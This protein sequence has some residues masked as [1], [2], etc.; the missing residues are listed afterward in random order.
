MS[1]SIL[2][3][4][5]GGYSR[6][7]Q[8]SGSKWQD[9]S[10]LEIDNTPLLVN[11]LQKSKQYYDKFCISVNSFKRKKKYDKIIRKHV[12]DIKPHF[13]VDQKRT[14]FKGVFLGISS[15]IVQHP[16]KK[17]QLLSSDRPF[18][19]P[20]ILHKMNVHERGVS[21]LSWEN[22]LLE[23]LLALYGENQH[24]PKYFTFLELKR[25][26]VLI[27]TSPY[28]CKYNVEKILKE[29]NLPF[30]IFDNINVQEN[31]SLRSKKPLGLDEL[32]LPS[33]EII[34]RP[35]PRSLNTP[36]REND[37]LGFLETLNNQKNHYLAFL[38]SILFYKKSLV[39]QEDFSHIRK[40]LLKEEYRFW[41]NKNTPFLA[42]HALQDLISLFPEEK[43]SDILLEISQLRNSLNIHSK[44]NK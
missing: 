13:V 15:V 44:R 32:I 34:N 28:L 21:L 17:I 25:A 29:N 4:L 16:R 9:K 8:K 38:W 12:S 43:N 2:A 23:P 26:D 31:I 3:I 1:N 24:F 5:A 14:K 37:I 40:S 33:P 10:L 39:N 27:R 42:Y 30:Y 18:M 6:R 19:E 35:I 20:L 36:F 11:T 7:F 22:G 41:L